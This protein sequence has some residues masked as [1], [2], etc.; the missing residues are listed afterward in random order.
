MIAG[1][2]TIYID[3]RG[4]GEQPYMGARPPIF[5]T[6]PFYTGGANYGPMACNR[7]RVG[8]KKMAKTEIKGAYLSASELNRMVSAHDN[9]KGGAGKKIAKTLKG[10]VTDDHLGARVDI[11]IRERIK[12]GDYVSANTV[13]AKSVSTP[14]TT[15]AKGG[16]VVKVINGVEMRSKDGTHFYTFE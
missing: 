6:R 7:Q 3:E 1:L 13:K 12:Y 9:K 4:R 14:T 2:P 10:L 5:F 15:P 11:T 16:I 8:V